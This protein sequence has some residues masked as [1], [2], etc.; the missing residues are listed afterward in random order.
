MQKYS[1][2]MFHTLDSQNMLSQ[3]RIFLITDIIKH[4]Y[5]NMP[6]SRTLPHDILYNRIYEFVLSNALI[7]HK[8]D[9]NSFNRIGNLNW[10]YTR[11][12]IKCPLEYTHSSRELNLFWA[13]IASRVKHEARYF[14][15]ITN[16]FNNSMMG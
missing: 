4:R 9:H 3:T 14:T 5:N 10:G 12:A 8:I 1:N 7:A 6:S 11:L 16:D 2:E 13:S 15:G